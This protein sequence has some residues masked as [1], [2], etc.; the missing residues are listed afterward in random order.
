MRLLG[1]FDGHGA[2]GGELAQLI[3]DRL[4]AALFADGSLG[5][6]PHAALRKAVLSTDAQ[7]AQQ[8]R[9]RRTPR[10]APLL[11]L[12]VETRLVVATVGD[13]RCV[14]AI[15]DALG[16]LHAVLLSLL[17]A[18]DQPEELARITESGGHV[19]PAADG[20]PAR[21]YFSAGVDGCRRRARWRAPRVSDRDHVRAVDRRPRAVAARQVRAPRVRRRLGHGVAA[22]GG[23][24]FAGERHATRGCRALIRE[25][26]RRWAARGAYRDDITAVA[27]VLDATAV[28]A[29]PE[30]LL[31]PADDGSN[32]GRLSR[33]L[34]GMSGASRRSSRIE[35]PPLV[36][37]PGEDW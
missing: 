9:R 29:D 8:W 23:R 17:H 30:D 36:N 35:R 3:A 10:A 34:S 37:I 14:L 20:R 11:A 27:A 5:D 28:A 19:E 22:G 18:P 21:V 25:A 16:G 1:L 7:L 31:P 32:R 2:A 4:P 33:R 12:F 13:S 24:V 6:A 15:G 26:M